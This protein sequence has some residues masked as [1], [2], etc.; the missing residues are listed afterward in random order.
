MGNFPRRLFT[1]KKTVILLVLLILV[2]SSGFLKDS[3]FM[4]FEISARAAA[5]GGA[6]IA[7]ADDATA[8]FYNPA[9]LAFSTGIMLRTNIYYP[10]T[11]LTAGYPTFPAL[12]Q[13]SLGKLSAS[14]FVSANI[15]DRIAFGIGIF[16][17][18]TMETQWPENWTGRTLSIH[19][20]LNTLY[21]RPV[22]SLKISKFLSI[23]IGSV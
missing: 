20:K 13:S 5:I 19:S 18:N 12:S 16:T 8:V 23:R 15:K 17:P 14:L 9:G 10:K 22:V 7:L 4:P 1:G 21:I 6:F 11:T 2:S 3:G